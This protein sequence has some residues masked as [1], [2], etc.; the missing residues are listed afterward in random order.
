MIN[1]TDGHIPSPLIMFTCTALRDTLME[2]QKNKGVH[3]KAS[4]SKLKVDRP[5]RTN[6]FNHQNDGGKNAPCCASTGPKLLTPPGVADMYTLLMN[7]WNTLPESSQQR[8][9]NNTLAIVKRQIQQT[10]NPTPAVVI[11]TEGASVDNAILLDY[12]TTDL[13]VEDP[14]IRSTDPNILIDNNCTDDELHSGM[15][16]GSGNY[17]DKDDQSDEYDAIPTA[18]PKACL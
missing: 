9:Y 1:G 18:S 11:S 16:G 8:V 15:P 2:W 4:K 10:E 3:Q 12:L 13:A 5:D 6:Y 7:T 17:E 14:E